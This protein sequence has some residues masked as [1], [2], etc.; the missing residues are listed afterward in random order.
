MSLSN[1]FSD[2]QTK[3]KAY[4]K[5]YNQMARRDFVQ[6]RKLKALIA[7]EA[8][9]E[10]LTDKLAQ[11]YMGSVG[12]SPDYEYDR[13][14]KKIQKS[15]PDVVKG[16]TVAI[17][18]PATPATP[19][20]QPRSG[21]TRRSS[22]EYFKTDQSTKSFIDTERM[23]EFKAKDFAIAEKS[24]RKAAQKYVDSYQKRARIDKVN[25]N[26]SMNDAEAKAAEEYI[27]S[28]ILGDKRSRSASDT[29]KPKSKRSAKRNLFDGRENADYRTEGERSDSDLSDDFMKSLREEAEFRKLFKTMK[30]NIFTEINNFQPTTKSGNPNWDGKQLYNQLKKYEPAIDKARGQGYFKDNIRPPP[31][32]K[33]SKDMYAAYKDELFGILRG[34]F[35]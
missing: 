28:Q 21:R 22:V 5:Y 25:S 33:A 26:R 12:K 10:S 4:D 20:T 11:L 8:A 29:G 32:G 31:K 2:N 3:Q 15:K 1:Y 7:Q 14:L 23:R 9:D 27:V 19:P 30:K 34:I 17:P 35:A 24:A 6:R 18:N 16:P 13:V